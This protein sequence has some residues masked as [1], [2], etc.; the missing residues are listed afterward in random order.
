[1]FFLDD[2][3]AFEYAKSAHQ[4]R[5]YFDIDYT[6]DE[7]CVAG[8]GISMEYGFPT[9]L[10]DDWP[11]LGES[12]V[13]PLSGNTAV[14]RVAPD[15]GYGAQITRSPSDHR[16]AFKLEKDHVGWFNSHGGKV[17]LDM[18]FQACQN[19][20]LNPPPMTQNSWLGLV[21][22]VSNE[23]VSVRALYDRASDRDFWSWK[24]P[25]LKW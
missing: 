24:G 23:P 7:S 12:V 14:Y 13:C 20:F 16:I 22:E 10:I 8:A 3:A 5:L 2:P 19:G 4:A 11:I 21:L 17:H 18:A 1:M 25:F 9:W 15:V 6:L